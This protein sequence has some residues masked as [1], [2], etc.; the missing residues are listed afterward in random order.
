MKLTSLKELEFTS[1]IKGEE[2][3]GIPSKR[4]AYAK[5]RVKKEH[6]KLKRKSWRSEG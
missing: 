2:D 4:L 5:P 6:N 3:K 1:W